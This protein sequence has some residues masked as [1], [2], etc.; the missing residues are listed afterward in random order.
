MSYFQMEFKSI[1]LTSGYRIEGRSILSLKHVL[2]HIC[3]TTY[4]TPFENI[5]KK[6]IR[7]IK[8]ILGGVLQLSSEDYDRCMNINTRYML[9]T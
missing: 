3:Y 8:D 5:K 7:R 1:M 6:S 4:N 9:L 2:V